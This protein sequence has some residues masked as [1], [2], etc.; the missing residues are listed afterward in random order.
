MPRLRQ[1]DAGAQFVG[2]RSPP[3]RRS[4]KLRMPPAVKDS[5]RVHAAGSADAALERL[6]SYEF[7]ATP[8]G[9]QL[10]RFPLRETSKFSSRSRMMSGRISRLVEC[11]E[12]KLFFGANMGDQQGDAHGELLSPIFFHFRRQLQLRLGSRLHDFQLAATIG[13]SDQ[14]VLHGVVW[15]CRC[16]G[17]T[18]GAQG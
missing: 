10:P 17:I 1:G 3:S 16:I 15:G 5:Q 13:A 18:L 6:Q 7:Q 2:C 4:C 9:R 8:G 14:F 11:G 12:D